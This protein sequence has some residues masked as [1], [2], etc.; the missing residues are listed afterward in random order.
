MHRNRFGF[1][2]AFTLVELLV[3][4]AIIGILVG[5]L[6]PAVQAAREAARRMQCSNN[7]KQLGLAFHNYENTFR[8]FPVN[9]AERARAGLGNGGPAISDTGKSWLQMILPY[10]EQSSL[11]NNIDFTVGLRLT[12]GIPGTTANIQRN[13]DAA[14]TVIQTYLCPSDGQH[15]NGRLGRRSDAVAATD[16][17]AIT[18]YKACAGRNWAYGIYNHPN[19]LGGRNGGNN[20]GLNAGNGV[21][22]SNQVNTNPIT[23][24][25]DIT[26]GTSNTIFTGEALPQYSQWNWWYNPNAVTATTAIPLNFS[27]RRAKPW[28]TC[29]LPAGDFS[30]Y[31][32]C[33]WPNNYNFNSR[34]TG[35][36]NFGLGDGGVRFLSESVDTE[37]YRSYGSISSGEVASFND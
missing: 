32:D 16:M 14:A 24:I 31:A 22:S 9:F 13:R 37:V 17:W 4:I 33:D 20:D 1:R 10:I 26:D 2:P 30:R 29:G 36:G 7:V 34:H 6:L 28:P 3:V 35:G 21:L 19:T 27:L 11:F 18:N 12:G 15:D 25:R 23:R 5:L 8:N